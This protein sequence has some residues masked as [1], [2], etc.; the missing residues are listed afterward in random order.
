[1][2]TVDQKLRSIRLPYSVSKDEVVNF[3]F[4]NCFEGRGLVCHVEW[5]NPT[6]LILQ[7]HYKPRP[8]DESRS[9]VGW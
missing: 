1:M 4:K 2:I 9:D 3:D 5:W 8:D 6:R 7:I